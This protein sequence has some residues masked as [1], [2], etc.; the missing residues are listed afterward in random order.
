MKTILD[1]ERELINRNLSIIDKNYQN[2][3]MSIRFGTKICSF[4]YLLGRQQFVEKWK[5]E[6]EEMEKPEIPSN[7]S[8]DTIEATM[9]FDY[10]CYLSTVKYVYG[11]D[12]TIEDYPDK[13]Y[14]FAKKEY[15]IIEIEKIEAK[16]LL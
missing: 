10:Y 11:L 13:Q 15:K 8:S 6:Y 1:T 16:K 3:R 12:W 2:N 5:Q 9:L 4:K 14:R 7:I